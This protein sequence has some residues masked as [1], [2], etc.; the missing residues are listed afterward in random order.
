MTPFW[1]LP[2]K[3]ILIYAGVIL[4]LNIIVQCIVIPHIIKYMKKK[5]RE[6]K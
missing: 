6:N 2:W 1:E 3:T 4:F 5:D